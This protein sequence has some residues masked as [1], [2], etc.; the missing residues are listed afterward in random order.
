[1]QKTSVETDIFELRLTDFFTF[2]WNLRGL[3]NLISFN[4]VLR[5]SNALIDFLLFSSIILNYKLRVL[6]F[7][8]IRFLSLIL[9]DLHMLLYLFP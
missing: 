6:F 3:I 9:L 5:F 1:M 8:L 2:L 7:L 4:A